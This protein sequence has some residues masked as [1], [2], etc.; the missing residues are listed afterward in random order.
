L[1]KIQFDEENYTETKLKTLKPNWDSRIS[2]LH[3]IQYDSGLT[4][5]DAK[6]KRMR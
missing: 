2:G 4:M 6:M 3:T 1:N 5:I